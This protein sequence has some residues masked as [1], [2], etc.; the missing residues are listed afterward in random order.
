MRIVKRE[1]YY[2]KCSGILALKGELKRL[3]GALFAVFTER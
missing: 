3:M 1:I 2:S